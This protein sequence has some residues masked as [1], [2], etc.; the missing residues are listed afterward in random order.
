MMVTRPQSLPRANSPG[1]RYCP[2]KHWLGAVVLCA[3]AVSTQASDQGHFSPA[4]QG[5]GF[6][7]AH[8]DWEVA[9]DNTRTCRAAGYHADSDALKVSVLLT[10][11]AGPGRPV[12]AVMAIGQYGDEPA[13]DAL[14]EVVSMTLL[15]DG[16]P[17]DQLRLKKAALGAT[18]S[19]Q[20]VDALVKALGKRSVIEWVHGEHR[21]RLSDRGA[22]AVLLKMDEF[23]GRIGTP[24]ALLRKGTRSE[25]SV[26]PPLPVPTRRIPPPPRPQPGDEQFVVRHKEALL[27]A[28]RQSAAKEAWECPEL[29]SHEPERLADVAA[30]RLSTTQ[31]LVSTHCWLAAYNSGSG[32]WIVNDS[33]PFQPSLV[34]TS[35][36][37]G[38]G[39]A[40]NETHKGRGLGDCWSRFGWAWD[41]KRFVPAHQ[42]TTGMCKLM[43]PGGA[44]ELPTLLTH[45]QRGP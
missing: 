8:H 40:I 9:C 1:R 36:S 44:W 25:Q 28:L 4:P 10:R 38:D 12:E 27:E 19:G 5:E 23:Q 41:G 21:W 7:F 29:D 35:G 31:M 16:K 24:G 14:P 42:S 22:A 32:Y 30:T 43:E 13:I 17:I 11:A 3:T 26:R 34:T 39:Q 45:V 2:T 15:I 18:L 37:D 6:H 33:P 20:T